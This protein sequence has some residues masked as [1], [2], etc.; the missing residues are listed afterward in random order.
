MRILPTD[1]LV[2]V[3]VQNDFCPSGALAV[4]EGDRVVPIINDLSARFEHVVFTRD[5]HPQNHCSFAAPPEFRDGSWPAHCVANSPGAE[6]HGDLH[7]PSDAIIVNKGADPDREAYSGFSGTDLEKTLQGFGARR[8]FVCGLAT[9]YCVKQTALDGVESGFE[10][11][12]IEDASRGVNIP[13]SSTAKALE[14]MKTAGV[15]ICRSE[16]LQ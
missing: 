3:D 7:A 9:D 10:V 16:D 11:F 1:A 6:L 5:W 14:D 8:L 13:P 12:L 2:V 15:K 4:P